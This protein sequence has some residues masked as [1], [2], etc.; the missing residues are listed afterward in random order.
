M[1]LFLKFH[2]YKDNMFFRIIPSYS[3][4]SLKKCVYLQEKT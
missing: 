2:L 1:K 4:Q 3:L